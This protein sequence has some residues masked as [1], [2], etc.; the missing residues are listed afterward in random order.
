MKTFKVIIN[1]DDE[2]VRHNN[3]CMF[4]CAKT[5]E[6]AKE[7]VKEEYPESQGYIV[8]ILGIYEIENEG[9]ISSVV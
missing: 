9:F 7:I 2:M 8:N 6:R 5:S 1:L 3:L 4:V